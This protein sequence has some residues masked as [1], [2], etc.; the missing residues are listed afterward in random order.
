MLRVFSQTLLHQELESRPGGA[1]VVSDRVCAAATGGGGRTELLKLFLHCFSI[2]TGHRALQFTW[3]LPL[4]GDLVELAGELH[5]VDDALAARQ[6]VVEQ[7]AEG[8]DVGLL[9]VGHVASGHLRRSEPC[10]HER[11]KP[12]RM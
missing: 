11:Q 9:V 10:G 2:R 4:H 1:A 7:Q 12:T 8:E 3:Q 6:Q 5:A